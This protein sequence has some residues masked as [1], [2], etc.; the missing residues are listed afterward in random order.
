MQQQQAQ[1]QK[2]R[3]RQQQ[4]NQLMEVVNLP[5]EYQAPEHLRRQAK[6]SKVRL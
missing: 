2:K 5:D 6:H 3:P 1:A 4:R